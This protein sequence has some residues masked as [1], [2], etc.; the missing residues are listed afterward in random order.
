[1]NIIQHL[2]DGL[3]FGVGLGFS[4]IGLLILFDR[5][6]AWK[7]ERDKAEYLKEKRKRNNKMLDKKIINKTI[8]YLEDLIDQT[9]DKEYQGQIM[10]VINFW[11][12]YINFLG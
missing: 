2:V 6:I 8:E 5:Y 7:N 12:T 4:T 1:M 9:D 3:V 11:R 10:S